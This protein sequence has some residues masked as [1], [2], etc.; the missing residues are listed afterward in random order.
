MQLQQWIM[1][2][3]KRIRKKYHVSNIKSKQHKNKL[4]ETPATKNLAEFLQM[5]LGFQEVKGT[6]AQNRGSDEEK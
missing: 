1:V 2:T 3:Q 6:S 4:L 5:G